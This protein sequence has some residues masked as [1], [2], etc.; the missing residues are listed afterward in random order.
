[1]LRSSRPDRLLKHSLA[2]PSAA[3]DVMTQKYVDGIPLARQ[4]KI[5]KRDGIELSRATMANWV[6]QCAQ[7]WFEP[8][9]RQLRKALL[10]QSVIHAD[11]T[12]VQVLKEEGKSASSESRMWLYAS[13]QRSRKQIRYE[14][15]WK[16]NIPDL[17]PRLPN[18]AVGFLYPGD[19]CLTK[20]LRIPLDNTPLI[21]ES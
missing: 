3:T 15:F 4:E 14:S 10:D 11:E 1:M 7:S 12:V 2:S 17:S 8:I 5:W 13:G 21:G 9:Y 16:N 19:Y 18:G 6:I 20:K